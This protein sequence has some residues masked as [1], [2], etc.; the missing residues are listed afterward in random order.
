MEKQKL[1][2][3]TKRGWRQETFEKTNETIQI[4]NPKDTYWEDTK[5]VV[6]VWRRTD[7]EHY[8]YHGT[9]LPTKKNK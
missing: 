1:I 4:K 9:F 2:V 7:S 5:K 8:E 6:P 3:F